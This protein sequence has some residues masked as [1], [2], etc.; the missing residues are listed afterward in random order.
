LHFPKED[1]VFGLGLLKIQHPS[2]VHREII[3]YKNKI[4]FHNEFKFIDVTLRNI[5]IYKGFIDIFFNTKN[6]SFYSIIFDK[7]LL[8]LYKYFKDNYYKAYNFFVAKLVSESLEMSEYIVILAD[9]VSTPR[10]DNFEK[11]IKNKAKTKT[12]RNA[13]FGICRVESHAISEI[14]LVDVLL[15]ITAYSFKIKYEIV[16]PNKNNPKLQLM[17]HLQKHLNI[18]KLSITN[19]YS[20]RFGKKFSIKEF[21]GDTINKSGGD[22]NPTAN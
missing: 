3:Q 21:K 20:L 16:K 4:K 12:R 5:Y 18:D 7:T 2:E 6:I 15:G 10:D 1:R 11:E 9:D 22:L 19:E 13:L 14:Q 17:K 8:D